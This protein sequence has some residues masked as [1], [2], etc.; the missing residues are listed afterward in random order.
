[1]ERIKEHHEKHEADPGWLDR[2]SPTLQFNPRFPA[3]F[4]YV[5]LVRTLIL[6]SK[7]FQMTP[8]DGIEFARPS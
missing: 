6:E 1:M 5:N 8:G 3:M 7:A 2:A 4:T